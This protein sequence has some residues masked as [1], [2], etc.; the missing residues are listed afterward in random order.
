VSRSYAKTEC[1]ALWARIEVAQGKKVAVICTDK[2][3]RGELRK[4]YPDIAK[5]FIVPKPPK[6]LKGNHGWIIDDP[7][8][9]RLSESETQWQ[10]YSRR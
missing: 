10:T 8:F 1:I 7:L 3:Q 6:E 9:K 4:R 2:K 5:C